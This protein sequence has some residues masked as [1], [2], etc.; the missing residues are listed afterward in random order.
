M[1][2]GDGNTNCD[3]S[4]GTIV[5]DT[6]SYQYVIQASDTQ[7]VFACGRSNHCASGQQVTVNVGGGG[8]GGS[9][10]E[11][12]DG[13]GNVDVN[14][15]LS[16][17]SA[18]GS[19]GAAGEDID[20]DGLVNVNDL[21]QLLGA[22]GSTCAVATGVD[23]SIQ[24]NG[25]PCDDGNA[26]TPVDICHASVCEAM[27]WAMTPLSQCAGFLAFDTSLVT[28]ELAEAACA[29]DAAC[30]GV[31]DLYC[32]GMFPGAVDH[33]AL[34]DGTALITDPLTCVFENP[35]AAPHGVPCALGE[36][37]GGQVFN[38]CGTMCPATCGVP[39]GMCNMMCNSGFQCANGQFWDPLDGVAG[40]CVDQAACSV[41]TPDL[42]PGMAAGRPF[43]SAKTVPMMAQAVEQAV[44]DWM[45]MAGPDG[46]H[47]HDGRHG[48][49]YGQEEEL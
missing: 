46:T 19:A 8:G 26:A 36:D 43:L 41:A 38:S 1:R 32:N 15:L 48:G 22:F 13:S 34:C 4:S 3:L 18:F 20:G 29:A 11:D 49:D 40:G 27:T 24:A 45:G 5:D 44:S 33:Y 2:V 23:C 12:I 37:C 35:S 21:L 28:L 14:D 25:F 16:V 42:P 9:C 6:G 31:S 10:A 30:G 17:L 47:N 7:I 39:M